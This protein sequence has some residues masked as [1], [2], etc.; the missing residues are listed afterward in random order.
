MAT[1]EPPPARRRYGGLTSDERDALRRQR[2]VEAGLELFG[3]VGFVATSLDALC[4][5]AGV[6][7]KNFYDHFANSEALL[8][9]VY[10]QITGEALD[11]VRRALPASGSIEEQVRPAL[12]AFVAVML[13]DDRKARVNFIEAIGASPAVE[14][15]RREVIR[16]FADIVAALARE[17]VGSTALLDRQVRTGA[18]ALVGSVQEVLRDWVTGTERPPIEPVVDDLVTVFVLVA[19]GLGGDEPATGS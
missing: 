7:T 12:E 17:H 19:Q 1:L 4:A 6:S 3:T 16:E 18:L 2:L 9:A 14:A 8:I 13:G 15:R 5:T 11:A 10:D